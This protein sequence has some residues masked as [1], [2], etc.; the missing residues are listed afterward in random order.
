MNPLLERIPDSDRVLLVRAAEYCER[1]KIEEISQGVLRQITRD[2]GIDFATAVLYCVVSESKSLC[3][4]TNEAIVEAGSS[5]NVTVAIIPGAFYV[6]HPET[7][8]DGR[9]LREAAEL[10]NC[11]TEL[12]ETASVGTL[13]ANSETILEWLR[14]NR[15]RKVVL[16][17]FSKGGADVKV[18]LRRNPELFRNVIGWINLGGTTEGSSIVT[19]I[20]SRRIPRLIARAIF[21]WHGREMQ[22]LHDLHRTSEGALDFPLSLPSHLRAIH[23]I[24][25]PL[26]N[27]L[28][29]PRART[30]HHRLS[31]EGP[32]DGAAMLFDACQL[33][34]VVYPVWG[35]DHYAVDRVDW[36]EFTQRALQYFVSEYESSSRL[37]C[38]TLAPLGA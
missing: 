22:F 7:G 4:F 16:A 31:N 1:R 8:A 35:A 9:R 3:H 5:S 14:S 30:W 12:I 20:L 23:V 29:T 25:F 27:H 11:K 26:R 18:A 28:S 17:S 37:S 32:N 2:E 19:W 36:H 10:L 21:W 33:P 6:E 15:G 34:G 38:L 24:G 13:S